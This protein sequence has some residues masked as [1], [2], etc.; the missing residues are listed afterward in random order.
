MLPEKQIADSLCNIAGS[1]SRATCAASAARSVLPH[2]ETV[3][4]D[5]GT[6]PGWLPAKSIWTRPSAPTTPMTLRPHCKEL[7]GT[8]HGTAITAPH[9]SLL[10]SHFS[11]PSPYH[12]GQWS[13]GR[14]R[15]AAFRNKRCASR[16]PGATGFN[17]A[18]PSALTAK[19]LGAIPAAFEAKGCTA[20]VCTT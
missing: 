19:A 5:V 13:M 8:A 10:A 9:R 20:M 14:K 1:K 6:A 2:G 15:L 12:P 7:A 18:F 4:F 11:L 17:S 16:E 3:Q